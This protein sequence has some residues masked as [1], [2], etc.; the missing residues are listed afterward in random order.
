M[1][2]D[3]EFDFEQLGGLD[4]PRTEDSAVVARLRDTAMTA[5]DDAVASSEV[6]LPLALRPQE[7]TG[8]RWPGLRYFAIAAAAVFLL[9]GAFSIWETDSPDQVLDVAD[10]NANIVA[11]YCTSIVDEIDVVHEYLTN[12]EGTPVD[13]ADALVAIA[14]RFGA[15]REN[16]ESEPYVRS[17]APSFALVEDATLLRRR[18]ASITR[19]DVAIIADATARAIDDLPAAPA[20]CDVSQLRSP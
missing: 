19:D 16:L 4:R 15:V 13:A 5:F 18:G 3:E 1:A 6:D 20:L 9:V 7:V 12:G 11:T 10:P 17:I 2:H 8:Q 14:E